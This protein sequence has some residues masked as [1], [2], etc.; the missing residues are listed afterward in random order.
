M[1]YNGLIKK[2]RTLDLA[3]FEGIYGAMIAAAPAALS[4]LS[5]APIITDDSQLPTLI[6]YYGTMCVG[7]SKILLAGVHAYLR[8]KT[9]GAVGNK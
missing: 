6:L 5:A 1:A 2:S 7:V 3:A 9:T 8:F 4:G